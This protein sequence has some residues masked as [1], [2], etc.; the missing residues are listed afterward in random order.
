MATKDQ[1]IVV[2]TLLGLSDDIVSETLLDGSLHLKVNGNIASL[3]SLEDRNRVLLADT[4]SWGI[5][6]EGLAEGTAD[7]AGHVVVDDNANGARSPG[8]DR[9]L[10]EGASATGDESNIALRLGRVVLGSAAHVGGVDQRSRTGATRGVSHD[11]RLEGLAVDSDICG[12]SSVELGEGL[13]GHVIVVKLGEAVVE[14]VDGGIVSLAAKSTVA[15]GLV[16]DVLQLL[17]AGE[18]VLEVDARLQGLRGDVAL[19]GGARQSW[20]SQGDGCG[21]LHAECFPDEDR[22]RREKGG[23]RGEEVN[24]EGKRCEQPTGGT[25]GMKEARMGYQ[26]ILSIPETMPAAFVPLDGEAGGRTLRYRSSP[27][28]VGRQLCRSAKALGQWKLPGGTLY[29]SRYEEDAVR[30]SK[31]KGTRRS[32]ANADQVP[33]TFCS[34]LPTADNTYQ[35]G[36]ARGELPIRGWSSS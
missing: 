30:E 27:A 7:G 3:E 11:A 24:W 10:A 18:E 8:S 31:F 16:G 20:Q 14:P 36:D 23:R 34:P 29:K 13:L 12:T 1:D 35:R 5:V 17:R 21:G 26:G 6:K 22:V 25:T 9:L 28:R 32:Q 15:V 19:L 33:R 2:V 4:H